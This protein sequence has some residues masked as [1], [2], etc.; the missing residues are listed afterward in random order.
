AMREQIAS[1]I[2]IIIQIARLSDGTRKLV[3]VTEVTGMEGDTVSLQDVFT[4]EKLGVREDGRVIGGFRTTGI[5]PR[6]AETLEASGIQLPA[7]IFE[8]KIEYC[9]KEEE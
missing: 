1:A 3:K 2:N 8:P 6:F 7:D 5:R 4:F 9:H